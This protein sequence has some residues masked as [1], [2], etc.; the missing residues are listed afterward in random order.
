MC[1]LHRTNLTFC[2]I[3]R[4][5]KAFRQKDWSSYEGG[6][7]ADQGPNTHLFLKTNKNIF[8]VFHS[9]TVGAFSVVSG[10]DWFLVVLQS[11]A[12]S[13][14]FKIQTTNSNKCK[15]SRWNRNPPRQ[16]L[17]VKKVN[18]CVEKRLLSPVVSDVLV[19][20]FS[21]NVWRQPPHPDSSPPEEK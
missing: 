14:W 20:L 3:Q 7:S 6:H 21:N 18:I 12:T 15:R 1:L 10:W 9:S 5:V 16:R 13:C 8:T 19:G 2:S 11:L 4:V 17:K